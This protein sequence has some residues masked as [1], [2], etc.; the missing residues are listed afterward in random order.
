MGEY[1]LI[2]EHFLNL[3]MYEHSA[4]TEILYNSIHAI[5]KVSTII[6]YKQQSS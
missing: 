3:N 2:N 1:I 6:Y 5:E 4:R